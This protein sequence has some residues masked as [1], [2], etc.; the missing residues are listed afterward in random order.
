[1]AEHPVADLEAGDSRADRDD[2]ALAALTAQ[3]AMVVFAIAYDAWVEPG[4]TDLRAHVQRA[5]V[6][7][8]EAV[9]GSQGGTAPHHPARS[10]PGRADA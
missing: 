3:A 1:V 9:S 5:L 7:L 10:R 4:G 8:K 2:L 6:D